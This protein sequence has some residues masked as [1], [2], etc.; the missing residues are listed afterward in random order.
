MNII[1]I[2][3]ALFIQWFTEISFQEIIL[4]VQQNLDLF[5]II[6]SALYVLLLNITFISI[7]LKKMLIKPHST[8]I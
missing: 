1:S 5:F 4:I 7:S 3:V 8:K 2:N 6:G